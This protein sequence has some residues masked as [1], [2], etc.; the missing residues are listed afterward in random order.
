[1]SIPKKGSR[2]FV[3]NGTSYRYI[4]KDISRI[5]LVKNEGTSSPKLRLTIQ[6]EDCGKVLQTVL[7]AKDWDGDLVALEEGNLLKATL[8]PADIGEIIEDGLHMGWNPQ[9]KGA[10]FQLMSLLDLKDYRIALLYDNLT[11]DE[12]EVFG[13]LCRG[14]EILDYEVCK[15]LDPNIK[16]T[17]QHLVDKG[18]I[19]HVQDNEYKVNPTENEKWCDWWDTVD[20][21]GPK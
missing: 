8:S 13:Y 7:N 15:R 10:A 19:S 16:V 3:H 9:S 6:Q 1:M 21:P 20:V 11:E 5:S 17:T 14:E 18:K 12:T 2:T 4:L